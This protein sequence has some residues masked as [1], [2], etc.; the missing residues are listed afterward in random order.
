MKRASLFGLVILG[1]LVVIFGFA[2]MQGCGRTMGGPVASIGDPG[3]VIMPPSAPAVIDMPVAPE[4]VVN[5]QPDARTWPVQMTT[6]IVR[7]GDTLSQ[8][9]SRY[10][11]NVGEV[12]ALNR[13][14]NKNK[15]RAGQKL[16]LPGTIDIEAAPTSRPASASRPRSTPGG[17]YVVQKGDCLSVIASKFGTT[18]AVIKQA[19]SLKNDTIFVGQKLSVKGAAGTA[20]PAAAVTAPDQAP[21]VVD[22]LEPVMDSAPVVDMPEPIVE[23]PEPVVAEPVAAAVEPAPAAGSDRFRVYVV[24][25]NEDLYSVGLLWNVS[26]DQIKELN[27][28][29]DTALTPGQRLKIPIAE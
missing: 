6:Y 16:L 5:T 24:G 11:L 12:M 8:I 1:H 23:Q 29:T 4:P 13:L 15:I 27:S 22:P 20:T 2:F 14:E 7:R 17:N 10:G 21:V 18:V 26:V 19:N 9:C 25:E 28:L 3:E